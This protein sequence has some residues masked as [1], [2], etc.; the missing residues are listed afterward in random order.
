MIKQK[1][2]HEVEGEVDAEK[3]GLK[4]VGKE[5]RAMRHSRWTDLLIIATKAM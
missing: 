5:S 3:R 1:T 2:E 4:M